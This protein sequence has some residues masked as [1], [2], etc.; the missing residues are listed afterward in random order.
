ME[1]FE[2]RSTSPE[3]ERSTRSRKVKAQAVDIK[4]RE[5]VSRIGFALVRMTTNA[6]ADVEIHV[7]GVQVTTLQ[8]DEVYA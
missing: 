2:T 8:S 5:A 7:N 6:Q 3:L 1:L 4:G